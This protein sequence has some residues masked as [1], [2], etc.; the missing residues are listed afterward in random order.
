MAKE[1]KTN[2]PISGGRIKEK[3][4]WKIMEEMTRLYG[5]WLAYLL[6]LQGETTLRVKACD[7]AEAIQ[8]LTCSVEREGDDYVITLQG[9]EGEHDRSS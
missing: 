5:G 9:R 2:A 7:I 8:S 4:F 6:R 3:E 1:R